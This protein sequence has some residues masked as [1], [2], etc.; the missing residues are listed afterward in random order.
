MRARIF[1]AAI[2][3]FWLTM[4]YLL[5]RSQAGQHSGIGSAIPAEIVW[6]KILTAPD[7]SSLDIYDHDKKIG[8]CHWT[9]T[10]GAASQALTQALADDY[11]PEGL[12]PQPAGY[13]LTLEGNS[14]IFGTNRARFDIHLQLSTNQTWLDFRLAAKMR[15]T[16][17][18][19]HAIAAAQKIMI[20]ING[21]AGGW[22]STL[23]FSDLQ[24][25]EMLLSELAGVESLGIAGAALMPLRTESLS[26]TAAGIKWDAHEDW[27]QFGHNRVRVYRLETEIFGQHLYVFTSRVGEILWVEAPNKLTFRN[28]AFNHF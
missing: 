21:D 9:A 6:D 17:I 18:E 23:K 24:H 14:A 19:V 26:Q 1:F 15:P 3:V 7:N 20:K 16:A 8:F 13:G 4:N 25:P 11:T 5:W 27:M 2:V 12:I 22:Q 10:V 28:E